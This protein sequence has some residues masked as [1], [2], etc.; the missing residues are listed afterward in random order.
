MGEWT[1]LDGDDDDVVAAVARLNEALTR[2][3]TIFVPIE[4]LAV[5]SD[6]TVVLAG[7]PDVP[8]QGGR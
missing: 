4:P 1:I 2:L 5:A 3:S 6:R 8:R 7:P